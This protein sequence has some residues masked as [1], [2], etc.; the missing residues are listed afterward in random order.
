MQVRAP[1]RR[2]S[3]REA[4][5]YYAS[6]SP[7]SASQ[8]VT[9]NEFMYR[10]QTEHG[11]TIYCGALP[12]IREATLYGMAY[13]RL[14]R[15]GYSNPF[16]YERLGTP[17]ECLGV[18]RRGGYAAAFRRQQRSLPSRAR[19]EVKEVVEE[20]EEKGETKRS[21]RYSG[22]GGGGGR[23]RKEVD[24]RRT[25][26]SPS[27]RPPPLQPPP[28]PPPLRQVRPLIRRVQYQNILQRRQEE[29]GE[30]EEEEEEERHPR[31]TRGTIA[32]ERERPMVRRSTR[33]R[34]QRLLYQ[35]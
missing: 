18:G 3:G 28:P 4:A 13:T 8:P 24:V 1:V 32:R 31:R 12:Y 21:G 10:Q 26:R 35:A 16:G 25:R 9:A 19:E 20:E 5:R 11:H 30:E 2:A 17:S 14:R 15:H 29:K 34:K 6:L 22:G 7:Y 33:Q 27:P 23:E